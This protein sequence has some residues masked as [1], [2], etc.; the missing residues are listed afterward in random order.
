MLLDPKAGLFIWTLVVFGL[1]LFILWRYA[2][3]PIAKALATREETI[4]NS[5]RRAERALDEARQ[6]AAD[7]EKARREAEVEAQKILREAKD[8]AEK[9][10]TEH[11]DE[12]K[13]Q[14]DRMIEQ[15]RENID[16]ERQKVLKEL[17][18]EVAG[19]AI[20]AAE[21]VVA[22]NMDSGR[23]RKIVEDYISELAEN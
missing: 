15:A 5:I 13:E 22:A 17:R 16:Q 7:N 3:G 12:T 23:N 4:D 18:A 14:V 6:I 9:L 1:V 19:L 20:E 8:A 11:L 2:W 10:R 21:K